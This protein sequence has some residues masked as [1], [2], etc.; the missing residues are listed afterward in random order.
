MHTF[1]KKNSSGIHEV[2]AQSD[3]HMEMPHRS[4]VYVMPCN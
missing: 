3:R 4:G 1:A 2:L